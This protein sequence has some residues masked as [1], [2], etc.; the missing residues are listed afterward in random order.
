[1]RIESLLPPGQPGKPWTLTLEGGKTLRLGEGVV[2]DFALYQGK[3][4]EEDLLA[5]LEQAAFAAG[6]REKAVSLLTGRLLSAGTLREKL[7]A[8]GGSEAQVEDI[9]RWAED[10]GLLSDEEYAKALARH[11]QA[12]GY[13]IY[14]IKD[15]LYRRQVP[16]EYWEEALA[17]LEAPDEII[18]RFLAKKLTDPEDRKQVKKASDALVRRGFTWSQVSSGIERFR[19]DFDDTHI[20]EHT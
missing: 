19:R 4:L 1:M 7:L 18:D 15:E 10:I 14:K 13:G 16:R 3:D 8:K 6:L 2:I 5:D 9:I 12:K 17:Q 11:Y 20:G